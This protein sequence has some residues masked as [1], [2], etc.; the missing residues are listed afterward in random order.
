MTKPRILIVEDEAIIALDIGQQLARLGYETVGHASEGEEAVRMAGE[1]RPDLVLMDIQLGGD[2]DG[3]AAAKLIRERHRLPIVFLTA[4]AAD[5]I[6]ARAKLIE[7]FGYILKPFSERELRTV[8]EMALYK[9]YP[10]R[11]IVNS[12]SMEE[13]AYHKAVHSP[14]TYTWN[15]FRLDVIAARHP[16][17]QARTV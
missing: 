9:Q 6:L 4:F 11:P 12:I 17:D 15:D 7:P 14:A 5:D 2:M 13:A 8:L 3:I 16:V 1:S 10:G